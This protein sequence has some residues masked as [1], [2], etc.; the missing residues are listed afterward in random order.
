MS[1]ARSVKMVKAQARA[2]GIV[3]RAIGKSLAPPHRCLCVDCGKEASGYDHR[4]YL[5]PLDIVPVCQSCN[6]KRGLG[7]HRDVLLP[8]IA[9]GRGLCMGKVERKMFSLV[10]AENVRKSLGIDFEEFSFRIG[11]SVP[12]YRNAIIR[13]HLTKRMAQEIARRYKLPMSDFTRD[14]K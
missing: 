11:Y 2:N 9:R 8:A 13:G 1:Q 6:M 10:P 5:K 4:D 12:S 14:G 3:G 7:K